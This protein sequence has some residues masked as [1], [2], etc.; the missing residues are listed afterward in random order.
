MYTVK[1]RF[2]EPVLGFLLVFVMLFNMIAT[3]ADDFKNDIDELPQGEFMYSLM[4]PDGQNTLSLYRVTISGV[5]S[6][7]RGE[8]AELLPSGEIEKRN[9]YWQTN[10]SSAVSAWVDETSVVIN[11]KVVNLNGEP[12]DSRNQIILPEASAKNRVQQ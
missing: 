11:D 1:I 8:V 4:S 6:A 2:L 7:I 12:Y 9:V 5:G 10:T 3:A